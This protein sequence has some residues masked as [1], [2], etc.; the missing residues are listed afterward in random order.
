MNLPQPA[1]CCGTYQ[2]YLRSVCRSADT[3]ASASLAEKYHSIS[4]C[5]A[6]TPNPLDYSADSLQPATCH[7]SATPIDYGTCASACPAEYPLN[8]FLLLLREARCQSH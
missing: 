7:G 2:S 1:T 6:S 8:L 4:S 5:C 3:R